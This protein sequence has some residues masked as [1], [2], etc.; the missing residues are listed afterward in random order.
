[1]LLEL[2]AERLVYYVLIPIW[3]FLEKLIGEIEVSVTLVAEGGEGS[4]ILLT[5]KPADSP[6][7]ARAKSR[8]S[9]LRAL[10]SP[11]GIGDRVLLEVHARRGSHAAAGDNT[12][13]FRA[14]V[15]HESPCTS[16]SRPWVTK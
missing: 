4:T 16:N 6:L 10:S 14:P 15:H 3:I 1:V 13:W 2:V 9:R 12:G 5:P 8:H 11:L 7:Y